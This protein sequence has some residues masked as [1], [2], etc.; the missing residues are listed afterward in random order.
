MNK[1]S[2]TQTASNHSPEELLARM[3]LL[4]SDDPEMISIAKKTL[5]FERLKG[6]RAGY[7]S[8]GLPPEE[9]P[10]ALQGRNNFEWEL[11]T[12]KTLDLPIPKHLQVVCAD[13]LAE[14]E[15]KEGG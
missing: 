5:A 13:F 12:K 3:D 15:Q 7:E 14:L 1:K 11:K 4:T 9:W 2:L 6:A 8:S 10:S